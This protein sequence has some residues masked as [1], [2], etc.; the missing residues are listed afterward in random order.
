MLRQRTIKTVIRATGLGLHTGAK[1]T[2]HLRPA[3]PDTGIVFRRLDLPE[4]IDIRADA[5]A[6]TDTRLCSALAA[7]GAKVATVEHLMSALAGLGVDNLHVDV[8]G[9]EIPILDG[10]ASPF[11]YLL[12]SAGIEEQPV[13]KRFFRIRRPVEVRDGDKWARFAP[14]DGFRLSFTIDFDHPA[15][16]RTPSTVT[17]DFAEVSYAKEIARARTFGFVQELEVLRSN[18]LAQGGNLD[19]AIVLDEYRVLNADGLRYADEFAKHK[20]LDAIGDL[21]LVGHPLVGAFSAYK[22]GHALNNQLLRATL[23]DREAWEVVTYEAA[24]TTPPAVARLFP[25]PA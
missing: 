22:S 25:Q 1:V 4:P 15:L 13:P 8:D 12:Q 23:A 24:E 21:Y 5:L 19:N 14:Y 9:P 3:A 7:G 2:L 10:S 18:G 6:V 11:V 16:S 17:V 20:V